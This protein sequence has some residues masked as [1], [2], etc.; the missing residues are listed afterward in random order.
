MQRFWM[1]LA[2]AWLLASAALCARAAG[3]PLAESADELLREARSALRKVD[4]DRLGNL[5]NDA[6]SVLKAR[7]PQAVFIDTTRR[8]RQTVGTVS[9]RT[10]LGV[11]RRSIA[12][13]GDQQLPAGIYANVEFASVRIDGK[14]GAERL[15]FSLDETGRWRFTGYVANPP[16]LAGAEVAPAPVAATPAPATAASIDAAAQSG[17]VI[18][19]VEAA[20]RA[21]AQAWSARDVE[22]YFAAYV[23]DFVPN[24]RVDHA[25]WEAERRRRIANRSRIEV[26]I[27][28][29]VIR[30]H[31]ATATA[32]FTQ[33]YRADALSQTGPKTL[34]LQRVDKRWL[35]RKE[36]AG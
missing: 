24:Q 1:K 17:A 4:E 25:A 34:E 14:P 10:W 35:I 16:E 13:G 28:N 30:I 3:E 32:R 27:E 15:S 12:A 2:G 36:V 9:R 26:N 31:G 33:H 8:A 6:S 23:P 20:V 19:E 11:N 5:W 22:R 29:L 21:W 7:V 18:A